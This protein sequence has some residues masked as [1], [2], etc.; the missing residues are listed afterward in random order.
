MIKKGKQMKSL[1]F[2]FKKNLVSYLMNKQVGDA[3]EFSDDVCAIP[4]RGVV[5]HRHQTP[6][7]TMMLV[8]TQYDKPGAYAAYTHRAYWLSDCGNSGQLNITKPDADYSK[9]VKAYDQP[10]QDAEFSE[11]CFVSLGQMLC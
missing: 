6:C 7:G 11:D 2:C 8:K 4:F 10:Y 1:S 3:F 5:L 9:A